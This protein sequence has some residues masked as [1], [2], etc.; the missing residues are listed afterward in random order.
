MAS[1]TRGEGA[2]TGPH[3]VISGCFAKPQALT[4]GRGADCVFE[5]VGNPAAQEV[6]FEA[7][8]PA[9]QLILIGATPDGSRTNLSGA[10]TTRAQYPTTNGRPNG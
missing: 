5:V 3:L 2:Q 6:A 9:G 4:G 10:D 1:V 7:L 8:R